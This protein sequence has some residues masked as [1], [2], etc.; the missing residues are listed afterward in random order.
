MARPGTPGGWWL[1]SSPAVGANFVLAGRNAAKL[2]I[3]AEEVGGARTASARLE[4]PAALRELLEP[5]AAVI[6]CAGPF[7]AAR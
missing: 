1:P 5:C 3:V 6:A 2:E 7:V 4:D